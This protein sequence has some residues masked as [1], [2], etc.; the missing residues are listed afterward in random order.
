MKNKEKRI[1]Y[2]ETFRRTWR[3]WKI[4]HRICPGLALSGVL[5]SAFRAGMPYVAIWLSAQIVT[6]LAG[7]RNP[8][9][10]RNWVFL[11]L[12][13][14]ALLMAIEGVLDRW[15]SYKVNCANIIDWRTYMEKR[16]D[17]DYADIESQYVSD[18]YSQI[19]QNSR[20]NGC[21][22][23]NLA[24]TIQRHCTSFFKILG[25]VG[26][27][28]TLF[29]RPVPQSSPLVVLNHPLCVAAVLALMVLI[30]LLSPA[31]S[32][33]A[34]SYRFR[35]AESYRMRNRLF[36]FYGLLSYDTKR[37]LDLRLYRQNDIGRYYTKK[38]DPFAPG[39]K[40]GPLYWGPIGSW[41]ALSSAI[42][43]VLTGVIYLFVCLKA[44]AGAFGVGAVTQYVGAVT[45]LFLGLSD[46]LRALGELRAN[47]EFLGTTF[48]L[49]DIPNKM[50][51]GSLTTEKRSDRQYDI[52]FRD[53]SFRYP[54]TEV[55]ALR[56]VNMKFKVGARLAVVGENGSG[57]TTFIKLLCRLYDPTEG[58]ILLNGINIQKYRYDDYLNIF[59]VVFQDF[60]LMA[61][62]LG[63]NVAGSSSYD[64]KRAEHCLEQA[65]FGERLRDLPQGLDTYLYREMEEDGVQVSGGEAQKIAI[66]RALYKDAPFIIL[67][68]PTAALDPITEAEIYSKFDEIAGDKTAIYI[69]H[70][71]SSCKFCDEIAVFDGGTLM[72]QG[73][74][75]ELLGEEGGKYAK[76]W[77]A[78]AQ[79]YVKQ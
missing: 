6:E 17:M 22:L 30:T 40:M 41:N 21:G 18:L 61:L 49:L 77:N 5:L 76:L 58:E 2:R 35:A 51:Q 20:W 70:R 8:V 57:K 29:L 11:L 4:W 32:N 73:G 31:C 13:S 59:S 27:S 52:E 10:L 36:G 33:K 53:V 15:H 72:Q 34:S 39:S 9:T 16:M 68:E 50:Y 45:A 64:R 78:Q 25:G 47:A 48:E 46:F 63:E 71:L 55:W 79:Y 28:I 14:S 69:S 42:S 74:H 66:A 65:G 38:E 1:T 26:L 56:H 75:E 44:W 23:E 37:A 12:G 60:Q 54:D 24:W 62:P 3:G 43:M 7:A 67:D 19:R